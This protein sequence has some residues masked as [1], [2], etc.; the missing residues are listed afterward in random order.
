[1]MT[2]ITGTTVGTPMATGT[3][4]DMVYLLPYSYLDILLISAKL[5]KKGRTRF[6]ASC[7]PLYRVSEAVEVIFMYFVCH[8]LPRLL[9]LVLV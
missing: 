2:G 9:L 1:M 5:A 8:R 4:M 3:M 6:H 7:T